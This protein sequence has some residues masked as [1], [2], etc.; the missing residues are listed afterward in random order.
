MKKSGWIYRAVRTFLQ[1]AIGY[2]A[3][4]LPTLFSETTITKTM[5]AGILTTAI[6]TGLA[7]V[8][9]LN[10]GKENAGEIG[11]E[12]TSEAE[13]INEPDDNEGRGAG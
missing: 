6:S 13:V 8:M 10:D 3:G 11:V 5:I 2:L 9:N 4:A 7:A 12:E 1:V